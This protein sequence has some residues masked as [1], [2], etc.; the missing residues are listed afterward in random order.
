MRVWGV[1]VVQWSVHPEFTW[2]SEKSRLVSGM[3]GN[4]RNARGHV[5]L[6]MGACTGFGETRCLTGLGV[7][8]SG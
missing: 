6:F 3:H 2:P 8:L 1:F 5:V 4:A 7:Y